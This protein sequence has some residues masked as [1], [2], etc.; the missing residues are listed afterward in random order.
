MGI[1]LDR[2]RQFYY[3]FII[4][5]YNC[6]LMILFFSFFPKKFILGEGNS[7]RCRWMGGWRCE[8]RLYNYIY[9]RSF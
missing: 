1:R 9:L 7:V 2:K 6:M 4:D 3:I 5:S 8:G